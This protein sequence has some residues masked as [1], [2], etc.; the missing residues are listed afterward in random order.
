[1][2]IAGEAATV[3]K[4]AAKSEKYLQALEVVAKKV[5]PNLPAGLQRKLQDAIDAA[6]KKIEEIAGKNKPAPAPASS[7]PPAAG[8]GKDDG[9][10]VKDRNCNALQAGVPG[11]GHRGG[12]HGSIRKGGN[13]YDPPRESH[14]MPADSA[15]DKI[16]GSNVSSDSKPAI[17]MD[18]SDHERTASWGRSKAAEAYRDTQSALI[19]Q[20]KAGYLAAMMMDIA[21]I[22]AKFGDKYDGAI[23]QVIAWAKCMRYI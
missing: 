4:I 7:P 11:P 17:Q 9:T 22:R 20:G 3:A 12:R 1:V 14:H 23:L 16:N 19:K 6:K 21:D 10:K 2:P 5:M 15:Y 8:G 18:K 13:G